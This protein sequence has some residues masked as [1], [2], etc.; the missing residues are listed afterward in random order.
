[1]EIPLVNPYRTKG[2]TL[3]RPSNVQIGF[4]YKDTD[5]N[6]W[7]IWNGEAWENIDGTA[8]G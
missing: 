3:Q 1:M 4:T 8:L 2:T 5:L 7:I 6:K